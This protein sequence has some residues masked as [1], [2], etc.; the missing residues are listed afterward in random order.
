[1]IQLNGSISEFHVASLCTSRPLRPGG[2]LPSLVLAGGGKPNRITGPSN[3]ELGAIWLSRARGRRAS[4]SRSN[5][6]DLQFSSLRRAASLALLG[7]V[8]VARQ[9]ARHGGDVDARNLSRSIFRLQ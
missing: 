4:L 5:D 6:S 8:T 3:R 2:K 9:L 1:M 7:T